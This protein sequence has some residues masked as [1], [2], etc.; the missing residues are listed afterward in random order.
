MYQVQ[1]PP[2]VGPGA[3]DYDPMRE[4]REEEAERAVEVQPS[5]A[6]AGAT[7]GGPPCGEMGPHWKLT[8]LP[9]YERHHIIQH[10]AAKL[11]DGYSYGG[12][13]AIM[14]RGGS[15]EEGSPHDRATKQQKTAPV[16]G[17]WDAE[18]R[19]AQEALRQ[20]GCTQEQIDQ[21]MALVDAYFNAIGATG[22]DVDKWRIPSDRRGAA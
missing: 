21:A 19:V 8:S 5:T 15:R 17:S 9:G 1:P 18:R 10:G 2:D 20:A 22:A 16:G 11:L 4:L 3:L 6:G 7:S 14:V 13:P 12:S